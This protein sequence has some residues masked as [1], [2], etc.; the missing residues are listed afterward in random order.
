VPVLQKILKCQQ[1]ARPPRFKNICQYFVQK[2]IDKT[3]EE[4]LAFN[5]MQ[6]AEKQIKSQRKQNR[7][8]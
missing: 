5:A 6:V 1:T 3:G 2:I 4:G 7:G 8:I